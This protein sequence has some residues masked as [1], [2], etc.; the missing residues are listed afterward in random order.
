MTGS[1]NA[2]TGQDDLT[3]LGRL[4]EWNY[5]SKTS[6]FGDSCGSLEG[7]SAGEL[8][9]I[10]KAK[11]DQ[12]ISVFSPEMCRN[13]EMDFDSTVKV[14]NLNANKYIGGDRTIDK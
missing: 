11:H 1:Y 4:R 3:K 13:I 2:N 8:F 9:P 12:I 5:E 7:A 14:Q 10:Q 6:F